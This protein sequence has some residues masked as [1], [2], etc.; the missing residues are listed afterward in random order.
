[1]D[2]GA[3]GEFLNRQ[4]VY[5]NKI[6]ATPL[7]RPISLYNVD[8]TP[9]KS[10]FITHCVWLKVRI[11]EQKVDTRFLVSD[12]GKETAI[13]GLPWLKKYNPQIDWEK[14]TM[15]IDTAKLRV[16]VLDIIRKRNNLGRAEIIKPRPKTT[17]EEIPEEDRPYNKPLGPF[18]PILQKIENTDEINLLRTYIESDNLLNNNVWTDIAEEELWINAKTSI[19]QKLQHEADK[20]QENPK[21]TLPERYNEFKDIFEK[22]P[23]ERLPEH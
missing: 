23:S 15:N 11:G 8:G 10:K 19:S 21:V 5:E 9:N 4:Y 2:S 13:L 22:E 20:A 17:M 14:G 18:E 1:M 3:Q 6:P 12:I 7:R 16:R